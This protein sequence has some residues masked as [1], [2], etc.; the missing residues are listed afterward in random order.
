M[1]HHKIKRILWLSWKDTSHPQ[2]GGA[3]I[4]KEQLAKRLA[5]DGF[6]VIIL[7]SAFEGASHKEDRKGYKIIRVGGRWNVYWLVYRYY[8]RHL[9]GW[10]DLVIDEINTIPFFAKYYVQE[11]NVILIHQLAR[12]IW[13]YQIGFPLNLLGY[14]LEPVYLWLLR[15]RWVIT[16]S[17]S[18]RHDLS[19]FGF[20][21]DKIQIISE[22]IDI[23]A[24][25][26]LSQVEKY[27][28][29]TLL[30]LG[31]I[32]PMKRTQHIIKAFE[33]AKINNLQLI[34]AGDATG[35]YGSNTLSMIEKSSFKD[36]I[37]YLGRV[38]QTKKKE[39]LQ[40][41]HLI[42]VTSVKEGWGLIVTEAN[43]Q[44]TPAIVYNVDGLRDS[45]KDSKTGIVTHSNTP[46]ALADSIVMLLTNKNKYDKMRKEAWQ[47]S[48]EITFDRS[49]HD[50]LKIIEKF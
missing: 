10:A 31:S 15:D 17:E 23:E 45:T 32:R 44:G 39:L 41:S 49:Y 29:P 9:Q 20:K 18:T 30:A 14:F 40:K 16:I 7:T 38:T 4:V 12:Q 11:K 21:P 25:K 50:L 46:T 5:H 19:R 1:I 13:F 48:Q 8:K 47:W 6:E 37:Q 3:E 27:E 33:R 42:I 26:D 35:K 34:I 2:A 24:I 43:S 28:Q 36:N 22:G